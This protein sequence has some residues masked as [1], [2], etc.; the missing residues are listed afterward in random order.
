MTPGRLSMKIVLPRTLAMLGVG[1]G[2][3]GD[4]VYRERPHRFGVQPGT[5]LWAD[6]ICK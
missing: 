2:G 3:Q 5:V 1:P 4:C 6:E